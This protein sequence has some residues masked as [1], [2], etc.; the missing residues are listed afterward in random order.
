MT[1]LSFISANFVAR[2]LGW[3]MPG[4]WGQGDT[5]AN[6]H[7]APLT[8]FAERF[9]ALLHDVRAL[10]FHA[11]DLWTAHLNGEWATHEHLKIARELLHTHHMT[12]PTVAGGFGDEPGQFLRACTV[13]AAVGARVLAG[14]TPLID[15]HRYEVIAMLHDHELVLGIENHPEPTPDALLQRIGDL[16]SGVIGVA[17][18]TGWF[19]TRGYAPAAAIRALAPHLVAVHLKDVKPLPDVPSGYAM[20]DMGHET[21][22]LGDG[23]ADIPACLESLLAA[24]YAGSLALEHEPETH[25]PRDDIRLSL[26]RVHEWLAPLS[27][28]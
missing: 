13:A 22:A 7:F 5:A 28:Q 1:P 21:C 12:V 16:S 27:A 11:I 18:D 4:G 17:L 2:E 23:I 9:D 25:D 19:A 8:T 6:Q 14:S 24:G 20:K 3:H 26:Q 15:T 10:G